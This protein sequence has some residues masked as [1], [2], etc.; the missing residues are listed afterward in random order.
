MKKLTWYFDFISPFAYL[1]FCQLDKL[2]ADVEIEF[3]PILLAGLLNHWNNVGPAEVAPKRTFTYKHC[4]WLAKKNNIPY[5]TPPAHPF[6]SL[7]ALRL[8]IALNSH[9]SIKVIFEAIWGLGLAI[10]SPEAINYIESQLKIDNMAELISNPAVKQ[11]LKNNTEEAAAN[12]VFGVPT[13][14][15]HT[16]P[17]EIFWGL[18]S[19]AML[20]DFIQSPDEFR[21]AEMRRIENLPIGVQRLKN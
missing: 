14:M 18:D 21:D 15:S 7:S 1:Q 11:E 5:K 20:L 13:F 12:Q 19:Y 8:A 2:P 9:E 3:K 17:Q 6:N 4:Y 16:Q 10:D